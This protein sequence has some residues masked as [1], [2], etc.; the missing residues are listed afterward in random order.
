MSKKSRQL[1]DVV[2]KT[3]NAKTTSKMSKSQKMRA[4]YNYLVSPEFRYIHKRQFQNTPSWKMDYAYEMLTTKSGICYNFASAFGFIAKELG[5]DAKMIPGG[6][7]SL[8]GVYQ[9]HAWVEITMSGKDYVFD[10]SMEHGTHRDFYKKTYKQTG[11]E[12]VKP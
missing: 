9:V 11:R 8:R 1:Y 6:L 4:C 2:W 5:Y 12:Y 10:A 7:M 3:I